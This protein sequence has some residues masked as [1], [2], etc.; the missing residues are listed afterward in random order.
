M[1]LLIN[2]HQAFLVV[3]EAVIFDTDNTLYAYDP[4]HHQ[5]MK[6]VNQK[7]C[8]LLGV[9]PN[10]FNSAYKQARDQIK[11]HLG[12]TASSHS[13]LLYFQRAIEILGMKTQL[14]MTLDLE[15]T[16]WRTF[17]GAAEIFP[18]V[19][20]FVQDLRTAGIR[21]AIITDLTAQIQF[22]KIIYF[23][24]DN[25][26]DYV[27]T[28]EEA[29]ADKPAKA[30]FEIAL[31]KLRVR[32]EKCWM[33]GDNAHADIVGARLLNIVT[34]Q[35]R[36]EG[37]VVPEGDEAA[38]AVFDHFSDLRSL[39]YSREWISDGFEEEHA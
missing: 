16:Y 27:V 33:I 24:L 22:R 9:S 18:S 29:G 38:D 7:A 34:L 21:T 28:S 4:P 20:D 36:H 11:K 19:Q 1:T 5:A 25:Y 14:L 23:G 30:P 6:A 8:K 37:V 32:P 26:F 35:K 31:D 39:L 13:R 3:P 12:K 17:L 15:Q 10:D 2:T